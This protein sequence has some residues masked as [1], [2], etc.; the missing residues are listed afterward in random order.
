MKIKTIIARVALIGVFLLPFFQ[1]GQAEEKVEPKVAPAKSAAPA[2][3]KRYR[4]LKNTP[5]RAGTTTSIVAQ[6]KPQDKKTSLQVWL[7]RMKK[8]ITMTETKHNK[9]VAVASVRGDDSADA[10][11]LYWKGKASE[12]TIAMPELKEF[13]DAIN[14]AMGGDSGGAQAKLE[15]FVA[16]NPNSP[17]VSDA[18]ETLAALKADPQNP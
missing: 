17:L 4:S 14:R 13:D 12:G 10:P 7:K 2:P 5:K 6:E 11:P 9:L 18:Q 15:A 8:K 16:T 1:M 3:R